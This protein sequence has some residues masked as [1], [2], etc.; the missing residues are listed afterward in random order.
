M[1]KTLIILY[2]AMASMQSC[3][4]NK[5]QN[6]ESQ[7]QLA[8]EATTAPAEG[9]EP[10]NVAPAFAAQ[11]LEGKE[12]VLNNFAGKYVVL[13]FWGIWCKWCV[14]GIPEMKKY[15]AQYAEKMEIISIDCRDEKE[16]LVK[17]VQ[18]NEMNW[19]HVMNDPKPENDLCK[20]YQVKGFP[21]KVIIDPEGKI[22][23]VFVGEVPE[24]YQK[25][26]QL[27]K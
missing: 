18:E 10:G 21:T 12:I 8:A 26:D 16:N 13:D 2:L 3:T 1:K 27:L 15:Y 22:V 4:T 9:I 6:S 24:F 11:T 7:E 20:R 19:T 5:A 25:L 14:L 23:E 17:F